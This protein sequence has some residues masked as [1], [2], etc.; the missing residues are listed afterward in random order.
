MPIRS[1]LRTRFVSCAEQIDTQL[2]LIDVEFVVI[3]TGEFINVT[4][5]A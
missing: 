4:D 5:N 3:P 1:L 2:L